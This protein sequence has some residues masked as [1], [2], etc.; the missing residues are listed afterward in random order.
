MGELDAAL[1]NAA[2][3]FAVGEELNLLQG[4]AAQAQPR[5]CTGYGL[6]AKSA[7]RGPSAQ[8]A[9]GN[10]A[11]TEQLRAGHGLGPQRAPGRD[12]PL[13]DRRCRRSTPAAANL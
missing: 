12:A 8:R 4:D 3:G 2:R 6:A 9:L 5:R 10:I 7:S 1:A 11:R 13:V